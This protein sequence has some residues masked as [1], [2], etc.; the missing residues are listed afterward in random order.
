MSALLM[1]TWGLT[2][3]FKWCIQCH[4][5]TKLQ[6][7]GQR[8]NLLG[9]FAC[10]GNACGERTLGLML[11]IFFF[12]SL[13]YSILVSNPLIFQ[14]NLSILFFFKFHPCSFDCGRD[15]LNLKVVS[16]IILCY[17]FLF[18]IIYKIRSFLILSFF[19][20]FIYQIWFQFF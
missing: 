10:L 1:S 16:W 12:L 7:L 3:K 14:T 8:W 6:L 13:L 20:F 18:E 11:M 5:A 17:F 19:I 4:L 9:G 2:V 15:S